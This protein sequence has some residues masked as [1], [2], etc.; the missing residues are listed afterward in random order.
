MIDAYA[1]L[2]HYAEHLAPVWA[3]L[4]ESARGTFWSPDHAHRW[5][6]GLDG[7][8]DTSRLVLVASY[9][10]ALMMD[11]S[12]LVLV[13]HGAG[14]TY[15]GVTEGSYAGGR[16]HQRVRLFL[17]PNEHVA[18]R[19]RGEYTA[20]A[21]VVGCPK[22]DRWHLSAVQSPR[23]PAGA[24]SHHP[25]HN[26]CPGNSAEPGVITV[27]QEQ[28]RA[29]AG[30]TDPAGVPREDRDRNRDIAKPVVAVTFHWDCGVVPEARSAWR[31]YD[32]SLPA[33]ARDRSWQLLG[34]GHPRLWPTISRRWAQLGVPLVPE[35][36]DVL[37]QADVL[38]GDNTS[39]LYEF[40]SLGRPVV[41]LNQPGYRR[42]VEHGLRFWSHPPGLQV[43]RPAELADTIARA[44]TDPPAVQALRAR[45][46]ARAYA[47][48][49]GQAAARAAAAIMEAQG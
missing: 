49:D 21:V 24:C 44:L 12:E 41:V 31:H 2:R 10:D 18:A 20:P 3:A 39:A 13:E 9:R 34:H 33:L 45:A 40:A 11:P 30:A 43:D 26:G 5:G 47:H 8:R 46:V 28:G 23:A 42:D 16:G 35:L 25:K 27:G 7:K 1:S 6:T 29:P 37:D 17:C 19:W 15:V 22:L 4:P 38:V 32:R 14:Q 48:T 36:A